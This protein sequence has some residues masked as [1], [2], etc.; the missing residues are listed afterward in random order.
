MGTP[1]DDNSLNAFFSSGN[2]RVGAY[3]LSDGAG[4][5]PFIVI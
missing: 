1:Y 3:D 5:R 4:I 2:I